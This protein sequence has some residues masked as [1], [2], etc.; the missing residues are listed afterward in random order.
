MSRLVRFLRDRNGASAVEMAFILPGFLFLL[1]GAGNLLLITYSNLCLN[2]ATEAAARYASV[3]TVANSGT[4]P[5]TITVSNY[6]KSIYKGPS[7]SQAFT[8]VT[9]GTCGSSGSNGNQVTGTGTYHLFYGIGNISVS[10]SAS[11]CFP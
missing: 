6:A 4:S 5:S 10:E 2:T 11:A 3:Q 7:I 9:T 8:Y 1:T